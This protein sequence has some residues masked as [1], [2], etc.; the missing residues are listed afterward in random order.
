MPKLVFDIETIGE[1]WEQMDAPTQK[2]LTYWLKKEAYSEEAYESALANVKDGLGFSPYTG[3]IVVIGVLDIEANKG[4]VYYQ[5]PGVKAEDFTENN[6]TFKAMTEKEMLESFWQ[7][8]VEYNEFISFNGRGFD[9]PFL[10]IRSAALK[11]KPSKDLMSN[12][13]LTSQKFNALHIDLMDQLSFYGAVQRRPK[14]HLVCRALGIKSPKEDGV[15]GDEVK[16][17]FKN[18]EYLKIAKYNV[19]DLMATKEVYQAW[20][21]FINVK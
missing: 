13:Y 1:D 2:A 14:L 5:A 11:V 8:I 16:T 10:M 9:V 12:R 4:V 20:N 18:K 19:G 3:E 15:D 6:I 21:D 7:G 17:L